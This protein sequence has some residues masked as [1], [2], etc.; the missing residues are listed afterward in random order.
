[1]SNSTITR[2]QVAHILNKTARVLVREIATAVSK[3]TDDTLPNSEV[4][5]QQKYRE[6]H[7][8]QLY[9]VWMTAK[10]LDL[11]DLVVIPAAHVERFMRYQSNYQRRYP[12]HPSAETVV[13]LQER[14]EDNEG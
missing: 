3:I 8:A 14:P 12:G 11:L 2:E 6:M 10:A 9:T 13:T 7:R 1:M 5:L 4:A